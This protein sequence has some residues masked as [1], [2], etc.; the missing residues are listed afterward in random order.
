MRQSTAYNAI[1]IKVEVVKLSP[2]GIGH[3]HVYGYGDIF[4]I[5]SRDFGVFVLNNGIN[6]ATPLENRYDLNLKIMLTN[7]GIFL[8]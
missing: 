3:S 2:V 7:F 1:H 5:L 4:T 8:A 6:Y